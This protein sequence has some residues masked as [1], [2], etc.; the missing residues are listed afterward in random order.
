MLKYLVLAFGL[1]IQISVRGEE[2]F[3]RT[4]YYQNTPVCR[5]I[6][7][8]HSKHYRLDRDEIEEQRAKGQLISKCLL[9]VIIPTKK[10]MIF[11]KYVCPSL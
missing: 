2:D 5:A 7:P 10:P 8:N 4:K 6:L 3:D 9:G 11:I 1:F